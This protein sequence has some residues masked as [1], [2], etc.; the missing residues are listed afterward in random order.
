VKKHLDSRLRGNDNKNRNG[1]KN[2][3]SSRATRSTLHATRATE[4]IISLNSKGVGYVTPTGD[5]KRKNDIEISFENLNTALHGDLVKISGGKVV[6][7]LHRAKAGFAGTLKEEN[8]A[9][10]LQASDLKMYANIMIPKTALNGA[11]VG[12]KIFVLI[13]KWTDPKNPPEGK[14]A[15][16]L[17]N[18]LENNAEMEA[19]ALERGFDESFP[20]EVEKEANEAEKSAAADFSA[21]VKKRKDFRGITTF[22]IDPE[23]AKDFDDAISFRAL[24]NDIFEIGIHIADVSHYVKK[25]TALDRE[26]YERGTS[27]YLVDR[28]V[29]ML[30]EA[31]S[32]DLCSLKPDVDRLTMS[33][34]FTMTANG[35]VKEQWFGRTVIHSDKRFTYEEAQKILDAGKGPFYDELF[36]LNSIAKKLL[37]ERFLNGAMSLDQEEVKFALDDAG[38]PMHVFK[39]VRGD[40]NKLIEEFMLLANKKVAEYIAGGKNE[41]IFVYRIHGEPNKEKM[42]DLAHLLRT[43]HYKVTLK[44]GIIPS[45]DLNVILEDLEG[46]PEKTTIQTSV[47]RSMAKAI[48]STGN[49]GHYGLA[50]EHYTHFTSPIRRYPDVTVHR[51]LMEHIEGRNIGKE[52]WHEYEKISLHSSEREK[53]AADAERA[54]IKYKQAEYMESHIGETFN[55]VVTGVS[56]WG[57]FVE[58][59][60]TKCEGLVR[61]RDMTDDFYHL[62]EKNMVLIGAKHKKKFHIGDAVKIKVRSADREKKMIDYTLVQ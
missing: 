29:P 46:K 17:G 38:K 28:T 10:Y 3:H 35:E 4:G 53:Y 59:K 18:P 31:L 14:V 8:G 55:G 57:M 39:K 27:V 2:P 51:L 52:H 6:D 42:A 43:M 13:T 11:K 26:A 23:D 9:Y 36:T 44:D 41:R 47:I 54:S 50:F 12:Q 7:I 56:E 16:V 40:T 30:P 22:T 21:E 49:I 19:I 45:K 20:A 32:N 33:A 1:K 62:D 58:E 5:V 25:G 34:V 15:K 61:L 60:E 48:Y 24:G 37:K